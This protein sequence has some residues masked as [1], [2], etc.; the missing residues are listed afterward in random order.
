MINGF[1]FN[2]ALNEA[3]NIST[4]P[5]LCKRVRFRKSNCKKCLKICPEKVISLD[6]GPTIN[7]GCS[8]CGLCWTV[9]PTEVFRNESIS[10]Q[11]LLNQAKALLHKGRTQTLNEKRRLIVRCHR[12][13]DQNNNSLARRCLG[14]ISANTILG[15]ALL[16]FDEIVLTKGICSQCRFEQGEKL[17]ANSVDTARV[18]LETI[19]LTHFSINMRKKEKKRQSLL[20]RREIF[21]KF[22]NI[23]K[24]KASSF[25]YQ[26][27][28]ALRE[29]LN[30]HPGNKG[31]KKR[32]SPK[33]DLLRHLLKQKKLK[34]ALVVKY[35]P[36]FPWGKIKIEE[37]KCSACGICLALCPTGAISIKLDTDQQ[38]FY[39]KSSLC[40]NCFLCKEA[41][42]EDAIDFD[43][44]IA[45]TD[46]LE[47]E[48]KVVINIE[49]TSCII[50]GEMIT[51]GKNKLCPTCR[52]RQMAPIIINV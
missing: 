51:A 36:E 50:C 47:G 32:P 15:T 18:L 49:L 11:Y 35:N 21:S 2:A 10:D 31:K 38:L 39:F 27:D 14:S 43:E 28:K 34:N 8:D 19:G 37:K 4:F 24:K 1:L 25:V 20:S 12:A 45:L 16:G 7:N 9:C 48:A 29:K 44:N 22:S 13:G 41:C 30:D 3:Q 33:R 17:L 6:P 46:I 40:T 5:D 42:P 52:K 23:V 26:S